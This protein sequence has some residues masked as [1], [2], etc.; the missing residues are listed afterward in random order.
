LQAGKFPEFFKSSSLASIQRIDQLLPRREFAPEHRC[1]Q[2][3]KSATSV[4]FYWILVLNSEKTATR[5][6]REF[7]QVDATNGT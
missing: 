1:G 6:F 2:R 4:H 5:Q 7:A 3:G